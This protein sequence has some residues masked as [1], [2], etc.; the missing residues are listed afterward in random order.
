MAGQSLIYSNAR[1]KAMENTLL[2]AEK[3]TRMTY[4]DSL[5]EAVKI[6]YESNYG[7]GVMVDNPYSF[8]EVLHAEEERVAKFMREAMPDKSGLETLLYPLDYH[9]AKALVKA[10]AVG[11]KDAAYM[12]APVGMIEHDLIEESIASGD[13][14][15]LPKP[16]AD[17][18]NLI[19]IATTN[20]EIT[21]RMID[22]EIDKAM[23]IAIMMAV[24][25]AKVKSLT[26]YWTSNIDITNISTMFRCKRID[27]DAKFFLQNFI[28]GGEVSDYLLSD[29]IDLSLEAVADK[30]RY[31]N[32]AKLVDLAV[33]D[34]SAGKA[35]ISYE[36]EWDNYLMEIFKVDKADIFSVAPIAGFYIA[37]KIELKMV[38]MI[39]TAIK[40][41]AS[42]AD[43]KARLRGFY[44]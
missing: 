38:R 31:T 20:G 30:L 25:A 7:G 42:E 28:A 34:L 18:L 44:A 23:Y 2:S 21:P 14:S 9:N 16:M 5:A 26:K 12:L 8:A 36:V 41:K 15:K 35:L 1:V 32:Y 11:I 17:A 10:K 6:L 39:L 27:A 43:I 13:F 4:A 24:K 37:K 33:V 40:N 19:V 22:I 29:L 3:I